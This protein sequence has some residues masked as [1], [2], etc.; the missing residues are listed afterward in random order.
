MQSLYTTGVVKFLV[1]YSETG[2]WQQKL[3]TVIVFYRIASD[4]FVWLY[5]LL[6]LNGDQVPVQLSQAFHSVIQTQLSYQSIVLTDS[7]GSPGKPTKNI[8]FAPNGRD[9]PVN[10]SRLS[11]SFPKSLTQPVATMV[12]VISGSRA[13]LSSTHCP[14]EVASPIHP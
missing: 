7:F 4:L 9:D 3:R 13:P 11:Q 12:T 1:L 6:F 14:P 5:A 10:R 2:E 8:R